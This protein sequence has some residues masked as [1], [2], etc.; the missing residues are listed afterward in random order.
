MGRLLSVDRRRLSWENDEAQE[1]LR[2]SMERS[3]PAGVSVD[4]RR[5]AEVHGLAYED[6]PA[7]EFATA[8]T[9]LTPAACSTRSTGR[10]F[11][12]WELKGR[13]PAILGRDSANGA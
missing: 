13:Y 4:R 12:V 2:G 6:V 7:P 3:R 9:G 1:K 11:H 5:E 8:I 10:R